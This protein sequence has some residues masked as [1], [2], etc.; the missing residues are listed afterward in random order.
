MS[1]PHRCVT[2]GARR[3]VRLRRTH[4]YGDSY[5]NNLPGA[6]AHSCSILAGIALLTMSG[7]ATSAPTLVG[8][9]TDPTGLN[10]VVIDGMTYDVTFSITKFDSP[11]TGGT[12][13]SEEAGTAIAGAFNTLGVT[14]LA[15]TQ[16]SENYA[17]YVDSGFGDIAGCAVPSSPGSC[18]TAGWASGGT[19]TEQLGAFF[20]P[21]QTLPFTYTVAAD[22]TRVSSSV[23]E[24]TTLALFALGLVG[25]GIARRR[26][27]R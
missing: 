11:F 5:M 22:F 23:P 14:E 15:G 26:D 2:F 8:T 6:R 12:T 17:V 20:P 21:D 16:V 3:I 27:A 10:G 24:P 7:V 25:V 19:T 1:S 18:P 4:N 9:T 13:A